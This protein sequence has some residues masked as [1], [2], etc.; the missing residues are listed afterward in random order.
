[1][2]RRTIWAILADDGDRDRAGV[3]HQEAGQRDG[4]ARRTAS[5]QPDTCARARQRRTVRPSRRRL[6]ARLRPTRPPGAPRPPRR[7]ATDTVRVT[8]P[9]YTYGISTRGG[10][11]VEAELLRVRVDG[12]GRQRRPRRRSSRPEASCSASPLVRG[13][14]TLPL[15][16]LGVHALGRSL[17]VNGADAAPAHG[18]A[19]RDRRRPHLHL[20][21]RRLPDR[22]RG[23]GHGLGP[24]GGLAAGRH[25]PDLRNTE[26]DS[27]ENHRDAR[28]GHQAA[29]RPSAP[30]FAEPRAGR[31]P[32]A[33][34]SVRVGRASS[35]STS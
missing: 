26:A 31:A 30:D 6:R 32:D 18:R 3:V 14:D 10:R 8:S 1:M 22:R 5:G 13:R 27:S 16:R 9:L 35:R 33:E 4:R 11:L 19:G 12:A 24:N 25:G 23:P 15:R 7:V 2:D 34:R 28:A 17:D 29:T 21:A 20:P